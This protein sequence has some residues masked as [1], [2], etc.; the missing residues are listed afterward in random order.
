MGGALRSHNQ[1][2]LFRD[3]IDECGFM[4]LGF[5][6][7]K[8]TWCKHIDNGH[9]IWERL[10]QGLATNSWFLRYPGTRV[11]HLPCLSSNHCPLFINPT[12]VEP[13]PQKKLSRFEEMWLSDSWCGEIVEAP[14]ILVLT[15]IQIEWL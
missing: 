1:M 3:I 12:G 11:S 13:V 9:S 14:G 7:P 2:Q 6:G 15:Q 10:D 4:D 8:F 5:I